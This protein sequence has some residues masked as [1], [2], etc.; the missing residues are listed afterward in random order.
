M[1]YKKLKL[2]FDEEL[3][4]LLADKIGPNHKGFD[5]S[6]FVRTIK[7]QVDPLELKDRVAVIAKAMHWEFN[8]DTRAGLEAILQSLGPEN[9]NETGMFTNYYW[10]MPMAKYVEDYGIEHFE[11]SMEALKEITKRNT[12]EYAIR[13]FIR[14]YSGQTL[15]QMMLWAKDDNFHVR[16]LAS[17]GGRPRLPWASKLEE[18]IKDPSPLI[19]ILEVLRDDPSKYVQNSVANCL[20]DICKDNREIAVS[21]VNSW[22]NEPT[23]N[24]IWIIKHGTRGLRKAGDSWA[25]DLFKKFQ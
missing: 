4:K 17:E 7:G 16:R 13:P 1:A 14:K 10:V 23:K 6:R 18:F 5:R 3:G 9:P 12:S 25:M 2:W 11:L 8:E 19:P 24:R 21:L 20:N 15:D 22:L